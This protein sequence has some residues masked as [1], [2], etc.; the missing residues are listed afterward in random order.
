MSSEDSEFGGR[1]RSS[2]PGSGLIGRL[3]IKALD[4]HLLPKSLGR[5][6]RV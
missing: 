3:R 6:F 5:G 4:F 1:T 2:P